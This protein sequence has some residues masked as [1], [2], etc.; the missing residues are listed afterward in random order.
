MSVSRPDDARDGVGDG[1]DLT[2]AFQQ[3]EK[4]AYQAI[5]DLH[6]AR[7]H[8]ICLRMLGNADDAQ[9]ASQETF[10]R[11]Y[12]ALMRFNGRYYLGAWIARIATNVC[13]DH[14]RQRGRHPTELTSTD[15]VELEG[16]G[17]GNGGG[18]GDDPEE[19]F[20]KR[21]EGRKVRR[22]LESLPPLHRAAIVLRDFEGLSYAEIAVALDLSESQVK[23]LLHRARKGFRRSW[24]STGLAALLPS[25]V[26]ARLR[27]ADS[28]KDH[29]TRV[30]SSAGHAPEVSNALSQVASCGTLLQQ[31]GQALT[32]RFAPLATAA[33]L[34]TTAVGAAA[35][36]GDHDA[37]TL[38][39][40][41]TLSV[42][43]EEARGR[44]PPRRAG[45]A[46]GT[47]PR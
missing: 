38:Q 35:A 15:I 31:C 2:L 23:A 47:V 9:E 36:A 12:Q 6:S 24:S 20:L 29:A 14:L 27:G 42:V 39:T 5:Y 21:T 11:V 28:T 37:S 19:L 33:L 30:A 40:S 44:S 43:Q 32:E 7:V 16:N 41:E 34:G 10:L 45:S 17:N 13:L 22:V 18:D 25:N 46:R 26:V 4:G 8:S 1:K 3:G